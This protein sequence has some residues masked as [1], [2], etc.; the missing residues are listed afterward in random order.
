[1]KE[2]LINSETTKLVFEAMLNEPYPS[3]FVKV[4]RPTQSTVQ[5]W[6]REEHNIQVYAK[7][8]IKIDGVWT[9]YVVYVD[10]TPMNDPRDEE[11]Q[12]YEEAL[13][14]GLQ[15]ALETLKDKEQ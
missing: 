2:Q 10:T 13:E 15:I 14:V 7:S 5:K 1:M 3:R 11:F 6:L 9:N 8:N 12:T 4:G